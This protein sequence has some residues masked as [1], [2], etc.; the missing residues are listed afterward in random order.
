MQRTA[1]SKLLLDLSEQQL[2][3]SKRRYN[4]DIDELVKKHM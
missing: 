4:K 3:L 1:K 2:E